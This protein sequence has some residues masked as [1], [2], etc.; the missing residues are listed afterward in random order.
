MKPSNCCKLGHHCSFPIFWSLNFF[1]GLHF[2]TLQTLCIPKV[3]QRFYTQK[4]TRM[5]LKY[6]LNSKHFIH[7]NKYKSTLASILKHELKRY[8]TTKKSWFKAQFKPQFRQEQKPITFLH[9]NT[10]DSQT[11]WRERLTNHNSTD[12]QKQCGTCYLCHSQ[13]TI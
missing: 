4:S 12:I 9:S 11:E 10:K 1:T 5:L 2:A 6:N 8:P 13:A 7:K 3:K